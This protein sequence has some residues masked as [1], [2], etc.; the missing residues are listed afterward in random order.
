[1]FS[2]LVVGSTF[3]ESIRVL[4]G[5]FSPDVS[6]FVSAADDQTVKLWKVE[7]LEELLARSC[8]WLTPYLTSSPDVDDEDRALCGLPPREQE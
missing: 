6:T 5:T 1:A 7:T 3:G 2:G 8:E 4:F